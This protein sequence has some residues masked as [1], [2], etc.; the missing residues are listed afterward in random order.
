LARLA[1]GMDDEA[2]DAIDLWLAGK[3]VGLGVGG[4]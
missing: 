3:R 4:I 1:V 2:A